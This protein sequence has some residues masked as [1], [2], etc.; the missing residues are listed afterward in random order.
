MTRKR[1]GAYFT[2]VIQVPEYLDCQ[3]LNRR[4]E[5][6]VVSRMGSIHR[7]VIAGFRVWPGVWLPFIVLLTSLLM[8][9]SPADAKSGLPVP[10]FVS[11]GAEKANV[12]NG[13]G[14]RY[15]LGWVF[16]RRGV[17]LEVIA[18]Y[19]MWRKIRDKDGAVGWIHHS[20]LSSRRSA[21]IKGKKPQSLYRQPDAKSDL[22]ALLEPGVIARVLTCEDIWCRLDVSGRRGWVKRSSLWGVKAEERIN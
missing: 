6:A 14:K 20:L 10:R 15:P 2:V 18:E 9:P 11:L 16:V 19:E 22:I 3:A 21:A 13:P 8:V 7:F 4:Y 1:L 5:Q 12:R 17:P